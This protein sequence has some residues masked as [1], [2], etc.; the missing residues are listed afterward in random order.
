MHGHAKGCGII[1]IS[2]NGGVRDSGGVV[3]SEVELIVGGAVEGEVVEAGEIV[4]KLG[5]LAAISTEELEM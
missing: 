5:L 3:E 2:L 1:L 4:E